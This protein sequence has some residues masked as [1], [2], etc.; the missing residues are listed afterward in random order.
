MA[1]P[2]LVMVAAA[3]SAAALS[4]REIEVLSL[5]ADGLVAKQIAEQLE[6]SCYRVR[7]LKESARLKL[8]ASTTPQAIAMAQRRRLLR[9]PTA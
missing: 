9:R 5:L 7:D 4:P 1:G 6:I 8:G 2:V 3:R